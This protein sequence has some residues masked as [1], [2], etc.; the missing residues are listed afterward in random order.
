MKNLIFTTLVLLMFSST[1]IFAQ[2]KAATIEF[3]KLKHDF[4]TINEKD[5]TVITT[6]EF[7]NTGGEPLILG[8]V[9]ASCGCTTPTWTKTPI[10]PGATGFV[11]AAYDPTNRPNKFSKTITVNS[12]ADNNPVILRISGNVIPREKTVE[13]IYRFKKDELRLKTDRAVFSSIYKGEVKSQKIDFINV[14]DKPVKIGFDRIPK[15]I[16]VEAPA[17]VQPRG[18]GEIKITYDTKKTDEWDRASD[19]FF[20]KLNGN[21]NARNR[22]VVI[23]TIFEDFTK[24]SPEEKSKAPVLAFDETN[25]NFGALKQGESVTHDYTFTNKGKSDLIIR[26]TKASCGCTAIRP[27]KSVIKPGESSS[28]KATFN[29]RGKKG[30]QNKTI[31]VISNDPNTPR[32]VLWIKGDV[33]VN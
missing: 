21:T 19:Y 27:A 23:A 3:K 4:G 8:R 31:T 16:K 17:E 28:I 32:I 20:L 10:A 11:K 25:F 24:M 26:K 6:F 15:H 2:T 14:S 1:N 33:T 18:K 30:R 22:I 29:S 13:D 5:G 12:N 7:T 9:R